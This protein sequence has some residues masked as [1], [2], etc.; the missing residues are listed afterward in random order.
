[1]ARRYAFDNPH[2]ANNVWNCREPS[3]SPL[4]SDA[5]VAFCCW[6]Q[7][8][9]KHSALVSTCCR[10]LLLLSLIYFS[11]MFKKQAIEPS[12]KAKVTNNF[13][14]LLQRQSC[15][16]VVASFIMYHV[17]CFD[18]FG[19]LAVFRPI[20]PVAVF[21]PVSGLVSADKF[22]GRSEK[23]NRLLPCVWRGQLTVRASSAAST[24]E[25]QVT[26][27]LDKTPKY[28]VS[29]QKGPRR[30]YYLSY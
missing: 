14:H 5:S 8:L 21:W 11:K 22:T 12:W 10:V 29:K 9:L 7:I 4:F 1:M 27:L 18:P 28:L 19:P 26:P 24:K 3:Q 20:L 6:N 13:V 30:G 17:S 15:W 25:G 2:G 16:I 23:K